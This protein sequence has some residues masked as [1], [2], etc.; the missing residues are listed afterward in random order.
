MSSRTDAFGTLCSNEFTG[1]YYDC[2]SGDARTDLA[3]NQHCGYFIL[4]NLSFPQNWQTVPICALFGF[5][6]FAPVMSGLLLEFWTVDI[7]FASS[8]KAQTDD[9]ASVTSYIMGKQGDGKKARR[10]DVELI[11]YALE[12]RK[13]SLRG[14]G[15]KLEILN[16]VTTRFEAGKLNVIMGRKFVLL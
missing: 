16:R 11:D 9:N 6:V 14:P 8:K 2:P 12:V 15:R 4:A 7:H 1:S 10:V 3:C 5:L 13:P